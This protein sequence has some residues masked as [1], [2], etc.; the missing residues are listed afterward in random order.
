M[1]R[2]TRAR[3]S[4]ACAIR[5]WCCAREEAASERS[6]E[7]TAVE[8][9]LDDMRIVVAVARRASGRLLRGVMDGAVGGERE[10]VRAAAAEVHAE[11]ESLRRRCNKEAGDA[12]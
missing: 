12:G 1:L 6:Q 3:A 4:Y 8:S 9:L 11:V 10:R 2:G 5:C 7:K